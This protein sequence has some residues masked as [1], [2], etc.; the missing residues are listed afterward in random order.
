MGLPMPAVNWSTQSR[1]W[2]T[3]HCITYKCGLLIVRVVAYGRKPIAILLGRAP[4]FSEKR[5]EI[6]QTQ[7]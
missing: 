5:C 6:G 7:A 4:A 1:N 2:P 3:A